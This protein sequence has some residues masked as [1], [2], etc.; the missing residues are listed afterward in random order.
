MRATRES[1]VIT[2]GYVFKLLVIFVLGSSSVS[3]REEQTLN[4]TVFHKQGTTYFLL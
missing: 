2:I 4:Y 3:Y 1:S